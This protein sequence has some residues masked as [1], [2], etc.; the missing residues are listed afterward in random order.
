MAEGTW[1]LNAETSEPTTGTRGEFTTAI[2]NFLMILVCR[3]EFR[4]GGIGLNLFFSGNKFLNKMDGMDYR[5]DFNNQ[6]NGTAHRQI[7]ETAF[8]IIQNV[9]QRY[10]DVNQ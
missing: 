10:R 3:P 2:L 6:K 1:K 8:D 7:D 5:D 9:L 4:R